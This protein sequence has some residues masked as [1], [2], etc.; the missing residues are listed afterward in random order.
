MVHFGE[1]QSKAATA[2]EVAQNLAHRSKPVPS[3]RVA[4][5]AAL[6]MPWAVKVNPSRR[7]TVAFVYAA[8]KKKSGPGRSEFGM[9]AIA[10]ADAVRVDAA[11]VVV[12]SACAPVPA[13][14]I[15]PTV[16]PATATA[17]FH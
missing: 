9:A 15:M 5:V 6:T 13:I 1:R 12:L 7:Q 11:T 3:N 2:P 17:A 4:Q 10:E 14:P 8:T 16:I